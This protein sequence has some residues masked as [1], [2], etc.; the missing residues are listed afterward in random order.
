MK[1]LLVVTAMLTVFLSAHAAP[2]V[3]TSDFISDGFRSQFNSFESI[4]NDGVHYTGGS[5]PYVEDGIGVQQINGDAGNAIWVTYSPNGK[6]GAYS[7]YPD[8][9]DFGYT[10]LTLSGGMDFGNVG[11]LIGSGNSGHNTAYYELWNDA[12][13]IL[14]GS[15]V[16][17]VGFHYL[18]F[19]GGGF[20]TILLRDGPS[21]H[22]VKDGTHNA[23]TIDAIETQANHVPEPTSL[24]LLGLGFA[25]LAF[26][27]RKAIA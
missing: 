23:L 13:L 20:D 2:I 4:P 14:A 5:G 7:W 16:H 1:N 24:A 27:R 17:Q 8:G 3:H 22:A 19:E 18:G 10:S 26:S 11:F 25:G 21:G 12:A 6:D 15:V 9:G